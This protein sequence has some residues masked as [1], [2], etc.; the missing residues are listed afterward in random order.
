MQRKQLERFYG[1][2]IYQEQ[3]GYVVV[4][5]DGAK[6]FKYIAGAEDYLKEKFKK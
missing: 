2:K 1:V 4:L 6:K 3:G 5:S